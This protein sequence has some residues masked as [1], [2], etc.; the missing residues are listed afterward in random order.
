MVET[1]PSALYGVELQ[2]V[3]RRV[4]VAAGMTVLKATQAR[5]S[6][7]SRSAVGKALAAPVVCGRSMAS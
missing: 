3:G 6:S 2:P 4:Q 1:D 5:V 7:W